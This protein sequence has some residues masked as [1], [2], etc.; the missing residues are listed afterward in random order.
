MSRWICLEELVG[1]RNRRVLVRTDS[2][3]EFLKCLHAS[4]V[5]RPAGT[6]AISASPNTSATRSTLPSDASASTS[7]G[8]RRIAG[9]AVFR[10]GRFLTSERTLASLLTAPDDYFR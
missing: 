10:F 5:I 1:E 4:P 9:Y 3:T 6:M 8:F 7:T 2:E